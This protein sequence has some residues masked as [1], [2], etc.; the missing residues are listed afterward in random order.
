MPNTYLLSAPCFA[1]RLNNPFA[2]TPAG[3]CEKSTLHTGACDKGDFRQDADIIEQ[4]CDKRLACD[5]ASFTAYVSSVLYP[6]F[7]INLCLAIDDTEHDYTSKP[8]EKHRFNISGRACDK[9]VFA[10]TG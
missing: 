9:G 3:A 6:P 4:T 1:T 8:N 5:K 2:Y 7:Y 10:H